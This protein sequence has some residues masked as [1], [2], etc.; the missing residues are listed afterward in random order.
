MERLDKKLVKLNMAKSRTKAQEMI[1][2]GVVYVNGERAV[3]D[4]LD[5]DDNDIIIIKENDVQKYVSRGG[6]KL[7]KAIKKFNINMAGKTVLDLGSSTGGFTDCALKHGAASVLSVDVGTN[8]M[9]ESLKKDSRITLKEQTNFKDLTNEEFNKDYIVSDLSFI[10]LSHLAEKLG[11]TKTNADLILLIKPQFE[12]GVEEAKKHK[13]VVLDKKIHER[14][15]ERVIRD[16][17]FAGYYLHDLEYSP[18]K[19]GDGNIEYIGL[20]KREIWKFKLV[21]K[22]VD[23]AFE[24]LK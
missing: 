5:V 1:S 13:G 9:D 20:F 2:L 7:E 21:E 11:Y 18:I 16:Y 22:I 10:S 8:L 14:V 6:L 15:I 4:S 19:G 24:N 23:E 3:K 17:E 12:C